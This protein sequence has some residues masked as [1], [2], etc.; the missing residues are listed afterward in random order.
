ML[1]LFPSPPLP[2]PLASF[3]THPTFRYSLQMAQQDGLQSSIT[4]NLVANI[5][6]SAYAQPGSWGYPTQTTTDMNGV[7]G[8]VVCSTLTFNYLIYV[9]L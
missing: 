7:W 1:P 3:P 9:V 2:L 6:A 5:G 4:E 8:G